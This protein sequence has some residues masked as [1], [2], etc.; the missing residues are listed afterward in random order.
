MR[1]KHP[2][3][4]FEGIEGSGK[5]FQINKVAKYLEKK[6]IKYIKIREPGGSSNS[7]KIRS[8]LFSKKSNFNSLTDLFLY[9]A[10]RNE[11][12]N[13]ILSKNYKKKI[14]LIDRFIYS[15]IAYQHYGMGINFKFINSL[16]KIVLKDIKPTHIFLHTVS[17][18][19]MN[20]RLKSRKNNNRYDKFDKKF[21][22]R[23]QKGFIK[24]LKRK[25]N[26]TIINSDNL[27]ENNTNKI[28]N[29]IKNLTQ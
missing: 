25:K 9:I 12:V 26:V 16:N 5:S 6:R 17:I 21:Y 29:K 13:K 8:L 18:S 24:M 7:E 19:N 15:T 2:L 27:I 20:K 11:N 10:S 4:I 28:I 1:Y 23:V 14:I 22:N 3:M